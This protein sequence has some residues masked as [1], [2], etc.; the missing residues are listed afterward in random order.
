MGS[1]EAGHHPPIQSPLFLLFLVPWTGRGWCR[2][3]KGG[4]RGFPRD[5]GRDQGDGEGQKR[6]QVDG[7]KMR[8]PTRDPTAAPI[9]WVQVWGVP[10]QSRLDAGEC[11]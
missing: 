7:E 9:P 11:L 3:G 4:K 10:W 1:Q 8:R 5:R 6:G 2:E